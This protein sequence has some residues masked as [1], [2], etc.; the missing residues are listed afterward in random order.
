MNAMEIYAHNV[1]TAHFAN[2]IFQIEYVTNG[3]KFV[4]SE[5]E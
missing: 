3:H 4:W 1:R 2:N 5:N